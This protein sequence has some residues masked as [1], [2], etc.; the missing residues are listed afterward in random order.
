[1]FYNIYMPNFLY[2]HPSQKQRRKELR[3]NS[4]EA[5]DVLWNGLK[6]K[7]IKNAKFW[8]QYSVGPY[9]LDFY[10]PKSRLAIELDGSQHVKEEER[11]YD[12]QRNEFLKNYD[13]KT[14]RFWNHEVLDHMESVLEKI[15]KML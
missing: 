12:E 15:V 2:N 8:R 13:I 6:G 10:C 14:L 4:T 9:I 11:I 7:Q 5:E 3:R 1:M